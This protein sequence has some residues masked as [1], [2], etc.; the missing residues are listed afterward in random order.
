[1]LHVDPSDTPAG[2]PLAH[3]PSYRWYKELTRYHWFV[4]IVAALGWLFDCLDQQLFILARPAAMQDLLKDVVDPTRTPQQLA[5]FYGDL[6]TSV[7]IFGW[8]SGGL[9]FGMLG[10]RIGRA[11]TMML[12]ILIYSLFTGLSALSVTVYDFAFYRFLTG[13]GVGGEFAVGVA[14]L[15]E[16][17]PSRARPHALAMLQSLSAFGNISAAFINLGL[18]LAEDQ[19]LPYS[20]W[21]IMFC[22]GAIPAVLTLFIR[23]RLKEPEVWEKASHAGAVSKQLGSYG[24]LFSHPT[25]RKHAILGLLL[26]CSGVV[27][28]W[29][30]GFYAPDL[31]RQ[32]QTKPITT[33]V[34]ATQIK[35]AQDSGDTARAAQLQQIRDTPPADLAKLPSDIKALKDEVDK[36][37]RGK[38]SV[39]QSFTS[40]AI[41]V[42]AFFGMFGFGVL[43]QRIGRRPTFAIALVA[44]FI[45]TSSVFW[46]LSEMWQ[47]FVL[48]PIMGF[49]QLSLFGGY[50]IYFPEL[51]PTHLRSTGISFCYNVGRF[52]AALGPLAKSALNDYF[53]AY[54]ENSVRYAGVA[55]CSVFFIGLFVLPFLP[56]TKGKPLPE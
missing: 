27:G 50:A 37:V 46:V 40:V 35:L 54:G 53:S 1:M 39:Y 41:N 45:S 2:K 5:T 18:G 4:F 14:L 49:C 48:V 20:P 36:T 13:L 17:M 44:A 28:L 9:F 3:D 25:W 6:A 38:L 19:G 21:R 34:Y 22:V 8:A 16:V 31:I 7:F 42:G 33:Q 56:E 23:R 10:D 43:S 30:V 55:M 24:Q 32:V 51:F 29:A 11:K 47:V 15:A 52:I 12:T 26:A